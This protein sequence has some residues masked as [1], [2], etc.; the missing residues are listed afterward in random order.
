MTV[1]TK[2]VAGR[3][4]VAYE[5]YEDLLADAEEMAHGVVQ[6][7]G[8][9]S[10]AQIFTHLAASFEGSID[11]LPFRA[12]WGVRLMASMMKRKFLSQPLPAGFAIDQQ[13]RTKLEPNPT[14]STNEAL[15]ALRFAVSR[16]QTEAQRASHPVFGNLSKD[17]WD[18]F[19][20]RHAEM[21]MSFVVPAEE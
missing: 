21:H 18:Q 10:L 3:R 17:E 15:D 5:S 7:L 1:Q 6:T 11:G 19:N 20:L 2:T 16:C 8:N 12:P 4:K 14:V 13:A 9:W